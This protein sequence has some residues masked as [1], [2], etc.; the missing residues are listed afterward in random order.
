M[1]GIVRQGDMCSGHGCFPPRLPI[2]WSAN[3]FVENKPVVLNGDLLESHCC[4]DNE[5][6]NGMYIGIGN[7]FANNR[8]IQKKSDPISCGSRCQNSSNTVTIG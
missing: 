5:C 1:S 7:V 8:Y 6:H 2:S 3:V 4:P